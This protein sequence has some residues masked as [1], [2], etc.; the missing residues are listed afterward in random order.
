MGLGDRRFATVN[1]LQDEVANARVGG[2]IHY[3]SSVE[4]SIAIARRT[5]RQVLSH[6]FQK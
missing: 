2:G 5:V 1:D 4:D 3:R 6:H